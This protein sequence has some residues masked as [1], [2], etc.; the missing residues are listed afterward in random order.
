[1][2]TRPGNGSGHAGPLPS[3]GLGLSTRG[4]VPSGRG[5][6]G[7]GT[8]RTLSSGLEGPPPPPKAPHRLLAWLHAR[9]GRRAT[10]EH[11]S[12]H[13]MDLSGLRRVAALW[14]RASKKPD[15]RSTLERSKKPGRM[16]LVHA[17][18]KRLRRGP[19][20]NGGRH[21]P[22]SRREL[23]GRFRAVIGSAAAPAPGDGWGRRGPPLSVA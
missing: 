22:D 1:M 6:L 8:W 2:T 9:R 13:A 16:V 23:N 19:S 11:P 12:I 17:S 7:V 10:A 20:A 5:S 15:G 14:S 21:V 3:P 4:S 18:P